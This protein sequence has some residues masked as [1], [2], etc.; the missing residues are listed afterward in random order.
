MTLKEIYAKPIKTLDDDELRFAIS[1]EDD[2]KTVEIL[3]NILIQKRLIVPLL[4]GNK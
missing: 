3:R 2:P 4:G 1:N